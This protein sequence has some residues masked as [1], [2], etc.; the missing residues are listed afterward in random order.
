VR[1]YS[2]DGKAGK[3]R[4]EYGLMTD[5]EGW[6]IAVEVLAWNTA[7]SSAFGLGL[8]GVVMFGDQGRG[9]QAR[10]D[11]MRDLGGL[12]GII[13]LRAPAIRTPAKAGVFQLSFSDTA[14]LAETSHSDFIGEP[15]IACKNPLLAAEPPGDAQSCPMP[16]ELSWCPSRHRWMPAVSSVPTRSGWVLGR[17]SGGTR[18]PSISPCRSSTPP[19]DGN[20]RSPGAPRR[21][22]WTVST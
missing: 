8:A 17:S 9:T 21:S 13:A 14:N 1:G 3:A 7:E 11:A 4:V 18:W 22:S 15:L 6:P 10:I 19:C 2:R 5:K 12:E 16:P 20:A